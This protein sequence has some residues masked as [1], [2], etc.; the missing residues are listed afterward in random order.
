MFERIWRRIGI[1]FGWLKLGRLD[2]EI[3]KKDWEENKDWIMNKPFQLAHKPNSIPLTLDQKTFFQSILSSEEL[4]MIYPTAN[5]ME[6][7]LKYYEKKQQ[8]NGQSQRKR[9]NRR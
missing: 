8:K 2:R 7:F 9:I 1:H 4:R 6:S 5:D 3:S